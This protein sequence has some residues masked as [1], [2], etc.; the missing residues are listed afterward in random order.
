MGA[1]VSVVRRFVSVCDGCG[2]T[3]PDPDGCQQEGDVLLP[4]GWVHTMMGEDLC[5]WCVSER[6]GF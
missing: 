6:R 4:E 3:A 2:H 1:G 5:G